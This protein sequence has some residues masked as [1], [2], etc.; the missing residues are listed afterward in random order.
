MENT[1][2]KLNLTALA[3]AP[4][5]TEQDNAARTHRMIREYLESVPSLERYRIDTFLQGSYKNS[6]NV[7][8]DSDVDIGSRTSQVY[9]DNI[10]RLQGEQKRQ[11]QAVTSPGSFTFAEY[12][13]DVLNALRA[14]YQ[15]AVHDGNK[16]IQIDGNTSRLSADVVPCLEYRYY[17][18]YTGYSSDYARGIA[19]QTKQGKLIVNFPQQHFD[20]L[21]SKNKET[22]GKVKGCVRILKRLRN[23]LAEHGQWDKARSSSFHLECLMWNVPTYMFRDSYE[24]VLADVLPYLWKDITEKK[25]AGD[26]SSYM[27]ANNIFVLFHPDFWNA[28]DALAFIEKVWEMVYE[29]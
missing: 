8:K 2:T 23:A 19:F 15:N 10:E 22:N 18:Q 7:R 14:K 12:R 20:N 6:T 27:Q 3:A 16:A 29:A 17:W 1:K 13:A 26:L 28:D 5:P 25:N 24:V 9:F 11:Y 21:T 4:S